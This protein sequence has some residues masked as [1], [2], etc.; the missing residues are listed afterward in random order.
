MQ[1]LLGDGS[2]PAG[3]GSDASAMRFKEMQTRL[4]NLEGRY[5]ANHPDVVRLKAEVERM[6]KAFPSKEAEDG[7]GGENPQVVS[8]NPEE[9]Q[10]VG[11]LK[12]LNVALQNAQ[13]EQAELKKKIRRLQGRVNVSPV[14]EQQYADV[15]RDHDV[16]KA[17]YDSL[18]QK[19][20][21]AEIAANLERRQQGQRFRILDPPSLPSL[22]SRPNRPMLHLAGV[23]MGLFLGLGLAALMEIK[24]ASLWSPRD[25]TYYLNLPTLATL[26]RIQTPRGR[27]VPKHGAGFRVVR[28]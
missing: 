2:V 25:V 15:T 20:N 16:A 26:P 18:L 8:E 19:R 17:Q 6:R 3:S 5:T 9:A 12:S 21:D 11:R 10:L 28:G 14:R 23:G 24:S 7:V 1:S 22:P 27:G 13:G 4:V